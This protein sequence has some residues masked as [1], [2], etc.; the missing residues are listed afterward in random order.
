MKGKGL[1]SG[2]FVAF[3]CGFAIF[4]QLGLLFAAQSATR[5]KSPGYA[6]ELGYQSTIG[7]A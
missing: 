3:L 6:G 1:G 5:R 7:W 4:A 2:I